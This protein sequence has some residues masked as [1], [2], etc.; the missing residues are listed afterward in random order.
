MAANQAVTG[1]K[2]GGLMAREI[3]DGV[4]VTLKKI[5]PVFA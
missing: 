2:V 4:H 1:D 5:I 3:P